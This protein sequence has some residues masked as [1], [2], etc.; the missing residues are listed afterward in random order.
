MAKKTA[1]KEKKSFLR[2][3][4]NAKTFL[5]LLMLVLGMGSTILIAG[6]F[7]Y[8]SGVAVEFYVSTW[9]QANSEAAVVEQTEYK[10]KCDEILSIYDSLTDEER[11]DGMSPEYQ[12]HFDVVLDTTFRGLQ[13]SMR[14][15]KNRNGPMNAFIVAM[16]REQRRMI[17]L[18]DSDPHEETFCWPGSWQD[19]SQKEVDTLIDGRELTSLEKRQ[20]IKQKVQSVITDLPQFGVRCTGGATLYQTDRYTVMVCVDEKLDPAIERSK[21]FLTQYVILLFVVTLIT[22]FI[23]MAVMRR[24]IVKP[25]NRMTEAARDY[26]ADRQKQDIGFRHFNDLGIK[27]GD[28]IENLAQ[29]LKE[30]EDDLADYVENL[31]SITAEKE[32]ISTE[33]DV[34]AKIQQNMLPNIFPPFPERGEFDIYATME[35]AKAVGGDFYDFFIIDDDHVGIEIA[36]VSDKGVPAALFMMASK[37]LLA[38]KAAEGLTPAQVLETVNERICGSNNSVGM[39]VTVWLGILEISTGKLTAAN[40]GHEHPILIKADGSAELI[41]DKHGFVI[42]GMPGMKYTD[43]EIQLMRGDRIFVYTDGVT[44]ATSSAGELFG[45]ER[46]LAAAGELPADADPEQVLSGVHHAVEQFVGEAEQFD[47]LT[48][49]CLVYRG[50]EN[51]A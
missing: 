34:A 29:T 41:R 31:T 5:I 47:D 20:G 43:Y 6:F 30:M 44:E 9:N 16:D 1:G 7:L 12:A 14:D 15:L 49:L 10:A 39:F 2:R 48:M 22:A 19:Y 45:I 38:N 13:K 23:G 8:A 3:S 26:G 28:E 18:V 25:I 35:P 33:L 24:K 40:A 36:D 50:E 27:T 37:I 51:H 46:T 32:R 17:Y 4:L 21:S 11:G 42:G